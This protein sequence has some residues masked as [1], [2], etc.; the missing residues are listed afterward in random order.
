MYWFMLALAIVMSSQG[1][2]QFVPAGD[3]SNPLT[4]DHE[5]TIGFMTCAYLAIMAVV[6][7]CFAIK[8][9]LEEYLSMF[10]T[11]LLVSAVCV[12][13]TVFMWG[14]IPPKP[15]PSTIPQVTQ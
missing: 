7:F 2:T 4:I 1:H 5:R 13:L 8:S 15:V 9:I 3:P 10:I 14:K 12:V 6:S 11:T